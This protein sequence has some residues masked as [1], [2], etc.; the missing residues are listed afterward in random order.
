MHNRLLAVLQHDFAVA[1]RLFGQFDTGGRAPRPP[2]LATRRTTREHLGKATPTTGPEPAAAV[3][4]TQ[5]GSW[6]KAGPV[7]S[8]SAGT[9]KCPA[10]S[11]YGADSTPSSQRPLDVGL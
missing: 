6:P 4:P 11:T 2:R 10:T 5:Q 8:G 9:T 1:T 7:P 3:T